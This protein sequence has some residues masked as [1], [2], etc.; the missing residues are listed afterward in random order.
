MRKKLFIV[1]A[2]ALAVLSV[3]LYSYWQ[4]SHVR[5]F[6]YAEE[7][8]GGDVTVPAAS[9]SGDSVVVYI[10]GAVIQPGVIR[11][12]AGSRVIDVIN[13]AGGLAQGAAVGQVNLAQAVKDGMQIRIS[14]DRPVRGKTADAASPPDRG[15]IN[16]NTAD[17]AELDKLPGIGPVLAGRIVEYRAAN[18]AFK[19]IT[20][21]KKVSGISNNKFEKLRDR[22]TL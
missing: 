12:P 13:A 22:I 11:V 17:A 15:K 14:G 9:R 5:E 10:S 18:G 21:L 19:D 16:I 4:K 1:A 8:A 7:P 20:D 6:A 2:L 3:S